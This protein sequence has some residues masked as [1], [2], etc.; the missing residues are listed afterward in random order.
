MAEL[1]VLPA[2]DFPFQISNGYVT[3]YDE[4]LRFRKSAA[5]FVQTNGVK[6]HQAMGLER[7]VGVIFGWMDNLDLQLHTQQW[8]EEHA[9][10]GTRIPT[11]SPMWHR[12]GGLCATRCVIA[13]H[14]AATEA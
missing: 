6:L 1:P 5:A 10:H 13:Q 14:T 2:P 8:T 12:G 3:S 11:I 9:R 4:V 7:R